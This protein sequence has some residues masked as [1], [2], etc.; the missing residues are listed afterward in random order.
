M[1]DAEENH[2]HDL[3]RAIRAMSNVIELVQRGYN[4]KTARGKEV[5]NE[6]EALRKW[7]E[8]DLGLSEE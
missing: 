7:L 5:L 8:N 2:Q 3:K 6:A 1:T 4:F